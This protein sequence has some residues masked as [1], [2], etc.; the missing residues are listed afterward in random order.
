MKR[1]CEVIENQHRQERAEQFL[2][3]QRI[4]AVI[5]ADDG[6]CDAPLL[7]AD[8]ASDQDAAVRPGGFQKLL[9]SIELALIDDLPQLLRECLRKLET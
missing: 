6:G 9:Q 2:R 4:V 1:R 5:H 8:F 3:H 7:T